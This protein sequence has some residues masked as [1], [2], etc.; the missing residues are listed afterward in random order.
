MIVI[1]IYR[2]MESGIFEVG[3]RGV[4]VDFCGGVMSTLGTA[5]ELSN[6]CIFLSDLSIH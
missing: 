3:V 1:F 6:D 4:E 2:Y 5:F